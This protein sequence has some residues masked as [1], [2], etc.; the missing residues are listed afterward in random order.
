[1]RQIINA[2]RTVSR[3]VFPMLLVLTPAA[4]AGMLILTGSVLAATAVAVAYASVILGET[5]ED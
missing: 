1:M 3:M 4:F 2:S 5:I